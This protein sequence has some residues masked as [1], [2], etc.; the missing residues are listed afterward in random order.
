[1]TK[2]IFRNDPAK[3]RRKTKLCDGD[4]GNVYEMQYL[5]DLDGKMLCNECAFD[6]LASI[7][8]SIIGDA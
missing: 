2:M 6:H 4:C 7:S 8:D 3:N 1:M 5:S